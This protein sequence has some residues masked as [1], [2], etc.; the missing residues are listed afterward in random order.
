MHTL[1]VTIPTARRSSSGIIRSDNEYT[2][3][4]IDGGHE[5]VVE[6]GDL[7]FHYLHE[8]LVCSQVIH[9][10]VPIFPRSGFSLFGSDALVESRRIKLEG[11]LQTVLSS[12]ACIANPTLWVMLGLGPE[13]GV[14]P[15]FL[16]RG[17]NL[18]QLEELS[19]HSDQIFRLCNL[20]LVASLQRCMESHGAE[21]QS[22]GASILFRLIACPGSHR[23]LIESNLLHSLF[24]QL[25]ERFF[26]ILPSLLV[27]LI[28]TVPNSLFMYV[29]RVGGLAE[30]IEFVDLDNLPRVE[31]L[32]TIAE[33]LLAGV[34]ASTDIEIAITDKSALGMSLLNKLLVG[35]RD[36]DCEL[37]VGCILGYLFKRGL[38]DEYGE[39]IGKIIDSLISS[40]FLFGPK[41]YF[42]KLAPLFLGKLNSP[43]RHNLL[44]KMGAFLAVVSE[45]AAGSRGT[46]RLFFVTNLNSLL[47]RLQQILVAGT[48]L[49]DDTRAV[50]SEAI[51][52]LGSSWSMDDEAALATR[53]VALK[54]FSPNRKSVDELLLRKINA[55][56][57]KL[58]N[59]LIQVNFD[60][61]NKPIGEIADIQVMAC[62]MM[63]FQKS[64]SSLTRDAIGENQQIQTIH[65]EAVDEILRSMLE[66]KAHIAES[67]RI[68]A[69]D[70]Q[71]AAQIEAASFE[72]LDL[73][74]RDL[75]ELEGKRRE[76]QAKL[77]ELELSIRGGTDPTNDTPDTILQ[78]LRGQQSSF[79]A[80]IASIESAIFQKKSNIDSL[81]NESSLRDLEAK[82]ED[83]KG[84]IRQLNCATYREVSSLGQKAV[85]I[86]EK[87]K[88]RNA[89]LRRVKSALLKLHSF[90]ADFVE[91]IDGEE[92]TGDFITPEK[93]EF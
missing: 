69:E 85:A 18:S 31:S 84:R 30:L 88:V 32:Q 50:V 65:S 46:A 61:S 36:S 74:L 39:K 2:V 92:G 13:S 51:V 43:I 14:V 16:L 29:Q 26:S 91:L 54:K 90:I 75:E 15:R 25:K 67:D 53:L 86:D 79:T 68:K 28:E 9:D 22:R 40:N 7:D 8:R 62:Q 49:S 80:N 64:V 10:A 63:E 17:D 93:E 5:S 52:M 27:T 55:K 38:V 3:Y 19:C 1:A 77:A 24:K 60:I 56:L 83:L 21:V 12:P 41:P 6:R 42:S 73:A 4:V 89:H 76:F 87:L 20:P 23:V 66:V 48:E 47:P 37:T 70:Y 44:I 78:N 59:F 11:Y 81:F 35:G 72:A 57:S 71:V 33:A 82:S 58:N 34:L 45:V